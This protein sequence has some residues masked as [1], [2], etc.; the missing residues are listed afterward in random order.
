MVCEHCGKEVQF[1][2]SVLSKARRFFDDLD[3]VCAD[4]GEL[5]NEEYYCGL[6]RS[7]V[8]FDILPAQFENVSIGGLLVA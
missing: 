4:C 5:I 1:T 6:F 2:F 8:P 3:S 7:L